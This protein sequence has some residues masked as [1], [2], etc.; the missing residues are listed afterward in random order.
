MRRRAVN[1]PIIRL[2]GLVAVLF[3]LLVAFTSRW[4]IFEAS[5]LRDNPLNARTLLEQERIDRGPILAADGTVLAR[6][7][8]GAG[9]HLPA[10]LPDRRRCSPTPSATTSPNLGSTGLERYRNDELERPD[11]HATCR[12]ILDQLQGKQTA[13]A[14]RS[15]RRSTRPPSGSPTQALGGHDGA[16]VALDPRTRGGH[17]D[18]LHPELRP[19]R[20]ALA[21]AATNGST[22]DASGGRSSTAPP[23]SATRPARP[24]RWSPPPPRSTPA[25]FTPESTVSGRNDVLVS[26]VPLQNDDNESFGADHAHRGARASRSTR[27]GRRSPNSSASARWAATWT[28]SASTAS[29]QLDYPADEMSASGEYSRATGCSRPTSPQVDVGRMGIGQDKLEVDRRCR[30]PRSPPPWP[31]AGTLMVPHLTRADRR[32]R[33]AHGA[34]GSRPRVQSVVM[35]PLHRRRR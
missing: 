33:R 17:G 27:S 1:R 5:S 29:P 15:S 18:G 23:S 22:R 28:A 6:S 12:A 25:R 7:V 35:K 4:T 2:Y 10:H 20:A 24:S 9:R 19:E 30:W 31:T 34:D 3:A 21:S 26:G 14:T 13:R 8:R 11:R 16:V 32:L